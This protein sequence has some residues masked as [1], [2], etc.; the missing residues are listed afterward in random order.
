MNFSV[1]IWIFIFLLGL[2]FVFKMTYVLCT[3]LILPVTKGALYVSTSRHRISAFID[4]VP[5]RA[6]Q[7]LVDLGC[8]DGRVLREARKHYGVRAIGYELNLLAYLKSRSQCLGY[9]GIEIKRRNFWRADLSQADVVC[10]YL[11]PDVMKALAVKLRSE[12]RS[13]TV[14]VS[15][16][17]PLPEFVPER[18]LRP[19]H[20]SHNDPIFIYRMKGE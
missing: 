1:L 15:C 17:F 9:Q 16:N 19:G 11:F 2:L 20:A 8:G 10:C 3:A 12:L 5:M 14:V 4:A 13:G 7:L 18:I 6:S